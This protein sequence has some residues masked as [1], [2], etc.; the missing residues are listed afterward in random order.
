MPRSVATRITGH[1]TE[2]VYRCYS[3]SNDAARRVRKTPR[4][5]HPTTP[6]HWTSKTG[7]GE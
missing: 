7:E 1:K 4:H 6:H 2:S 3:I 5:L